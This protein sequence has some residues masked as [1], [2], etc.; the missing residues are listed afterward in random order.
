MGAGTYLLLACSACPAEWLLSVL[1]KVS[2]HQQM[3]TRLPCVHGLSIECGLMGGSLLWLV[4]K[5]KGPRLETFNLF[6]KSFFLITIFFILNTIHPNLV[7]FIQLSAQL[8]MT[9]ES[10]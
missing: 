7:L 1:R 4:L 6:I 2:T 5:E 3:F 8:I 9:H 10:V